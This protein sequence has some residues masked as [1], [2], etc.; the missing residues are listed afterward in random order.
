MMAIVGKLVLTAAPGTLPS[1]NASAFAA[2]ARA[3]QVTPDDS[4][5]STLPRA[6]IFDRNGALLAFSLPVHSLYAH[7]SEVPDPTA[8]AEAL[9]AAFPY[10]DRNQL[11]KRLANER[12]DFVYLARHLTPAD[13]FKA[14]HLGLPGVRAQKEYRRVYPQG[15]LAAHVVGLTRSDQTALSGIEAYFDADLVAAAQVPMALS[16]DIRV[17]SV[18]RQELQHQIDEYAAKAGVGIVMDVRTGEMVASVSLPDFDPNIISKRDPNQEMNRV[19]NGVYELGSVFKPVV[20]AIALDTGVAKSDS[21]FDA[22]YPIRIDGYTIADF[23]GRHRWLSMREVLVHSSNIGA[24]RIASEIGV[25]RLVQY[26]GRFGLLSAP[27]MDLH[28][29]QKPLT[30]ARWQELDAMTSAYGYS[31]NV[32]PVQFVAAF[33]SLVNG[34]TLYGP[35]LL[36]INDFRTVQGTKVLHEDTSA[37][38]RSMLRSV[39]TGGSGRNANTHLYPVGGKTGTAL[40]RKTGGGNSTDKRISSF[41]GTFPIQQPRYVVFIMVDEPQEREI[42]GRYATGGKAAA[43]AVSRIVERIAPMLGVQP[44]PEI[45]DDDNGKNRNRGFQAVVARN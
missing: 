17:Q 24:A 33:S 18:V 26:F 44:Q 34:G 11:V 13:Y 4:E 5:R 22:R 1:A 31:L 39:V 40:K 7:P 15:S 14:L 20:A 38:V 2:P 36:A 16:L 37:T 30:P 32:S 21:M 8:T 43:P 9:V 42:T 35:T 25:D 29:V 27:S 19:S 3:V 23:H 12:T 41:V 45:L 10:L 6:K 28:E